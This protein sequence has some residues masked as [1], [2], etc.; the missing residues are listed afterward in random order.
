[1]VY[2][3]TILQ[4]G[5]LNEL[6]IPLKTPDVLEFI[7]KKLKNQSIQFQG[8]IQDPL[9]EDRYLSLFARISDEEDEDINQHMLPSPFDEETYSGSMIILA[10]LNDKDDYDKLA[11][12]YTDLKV[13]DYETLYNEWSFN[14]IDEVEEIDEEHEE[15]EVESI[16]IEEDIPKPMK[17]IKPLIIQTK[18]VFIQCPIR[19]K[20]I[21]NFNELISSEKSVELELAILNYIVKYSKLNSIDIDWSNKIF[22]NTYRSKCISIYESLQLNNWKDK[23]INND[24]DCINFVDLTPQEIYPMKW[25]DSFDKLIEK[26]KKLYSNSAKAS[27]FLYCSRCKKKTNC[28]YYQLQTRSADEP[29]TTFVTCLECNKQWKF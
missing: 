12:E 28:D 2:G 11:S 23:I 25:K 8:K 5:I 29:M 20:I 17:T 1:M 13:S 4:T 19:S 3:I 14:N 26:E 18:D 21:E 6:V 7:R 16:V 24:I 9:K 22:W 10:S 15:E 27:I